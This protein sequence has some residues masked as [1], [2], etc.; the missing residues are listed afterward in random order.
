[1]AKAA[2]PSRLYRN[3]GNGAFTDVT[4]RAG[5]AARLQLGLTGDAA[6][7]IKLW[8]LASVDDFAGQEKAVAAAI[9][10]LLARED[11]AGGSQPHA[12]AREL[13]CV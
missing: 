4:G 13:L 9:K 6:G 5:I 11:A 7:A 10:K 3:A 12:G 8:D 1:M 2:T